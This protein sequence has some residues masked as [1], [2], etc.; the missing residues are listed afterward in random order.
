[1]GEGRKEGKGKREGK[2][3]KK[4]C[5]TAALDKAQGVGGGAG[6]GGRDLFFF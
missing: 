4:L 5:A 1:M 2:I 6:G 3:S